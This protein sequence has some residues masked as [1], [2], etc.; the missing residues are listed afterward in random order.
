[1]NEKPI[2][3]RIREAMNISIDSQLA[4]S[5]GVTPPAVTGWKKR[6][7]VARS[8]IKLISDKTGVSPD[9]LE[10]GL[11]EKYLAGFVPKPEPATS[12]Q[13]EASARSL[14]VESPLPFRS[15]PLLAGLA[16][17]TLQELHGENN[18]VSIP[19]RIGSETSVLF[20]IQDHSWIDEGLQPGDLIVAEPVNGQP[21]DRQLVIAEHDGQIYIRQFEQRGKLALLTSLLNGSPVSLP[22]DQLTVT[23]LVEA[24]VHNKKG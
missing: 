13:R 16:N 14:C 3:M 2:Y 18:M 9:W 22:F 15:L 20:L 12:L 11:G 23:H 6:G 8:I 5:L 4:E 1:M 7:K 24:V 19:R 21:F 17:Q 10:T